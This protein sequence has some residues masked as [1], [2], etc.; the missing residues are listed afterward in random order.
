MF[1]NNGATAA[2]AGNLST[3]TVQTGATIIEIDLLSTPRIHG[4]N[5]EIDIT[6]ITTGSTTTIDP[7]VNTNIE[8]DLHTPATGT[9]TVTGAPSSV[10]LEYDSEYIW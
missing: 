8:V 3:S 6:S 4:I 1:N 7:P 10:T 5:G 2:N 9:I